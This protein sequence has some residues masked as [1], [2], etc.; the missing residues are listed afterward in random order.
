MSRPTFA[1]PL[2]DG[3]ENRSPGAANLR[4]FVFS[5]VLAAEELVLTV[6]GNSMTNASGARRPEGW[7]PGRAETR[8]GSVRDSRPRWGTPRTPCPTRGTSTFDEGSDAPMSI[9]AQWD[10]SRIDHLNRTT[11]LSHLD[12]CTPRSSRAHCSRCRSISA[13]PRHL[14]RSG[15]HKSHPMTPRPP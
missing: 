13:N 14:S 12:S 8:R 3:G 2:R 4:G 15:R 1:K 9:T 5:N 7:T 6:Q 10:L 11:S